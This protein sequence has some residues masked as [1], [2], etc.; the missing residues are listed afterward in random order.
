MRQWHELL[1]AASR[2]PQRPDRTGVG[3]RS[4]FGRSLS[5]DISRTFPAVTTKYLAF[6]QVKAEL[7]AFLRGAETL[8][9]FHDLGCRIWDANGESGYW[10]G[11]RRFEGDLGRIYG[12]Q[13]RRWRGVD[14]RLLD[15]NNPGASVVERDQLVD[16]L[17]GLRRDP[18]GRRHLVTA[19]N[20]AELSDMCLPPCHYAFQCYA[21][22]SVFG[23]NEPLGLSLMFHMRSLDVFLGM[24]F[25]VAS[26]ALLAHLIAKE[27]GWQPR[28]L[29]MTVGD[30]H[31][32]CNHE[33]QVQTVLAREPFELPRLVLHPEARLFG[34]DPNH[35]WL[36]G[37][38]SSG[39]VAA[40]MNV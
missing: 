25:D 3:T 9:E 29:V 40:P 5:W 17:D 31:V 32:Y 11:R 30:A 34:F 4:V 36:T 35:A 7:A 19:W 8:Q 18:F 38:Q 28:E 20:P 1:T 33:R 6:G 27:L 37:Y 13:W 24:P 15:S 23:D 21:S 12:A 22:Q 14:A 39:I 16:L 10:L 2:A 26:Y